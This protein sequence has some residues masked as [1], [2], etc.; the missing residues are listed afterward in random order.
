MRRG[1]SAGR[2]LH[3]L[4]LV[5][6]WLSTQ[7]LAEPD[8]RIERTQ[9][10]FRIDAS[11][12][13]DVHHHI[14]W[15]VMTDYNN[16][17]AFVPGIRTSQVVSVPGEPL[18]VRQTGQ[19]GFLF[20]NVPVEVVTRIEEFPLEAI[21]F[22]AVSGNLK[23]KS[24]EWRI[25]ARGEATLISYQANIVPGFWVPPLIGAAVIG[26]DVRN[27]LVGVGQEMQRRAASAASEISGRS[28][29]Q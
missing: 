13:V 8:I 16:Q 29:K 9:D 17:A 3:L 22:Y 7:T 5:L 15:Q 1:A 21:R 28:V 10:T 4:L 20:F 2:M 6:L 12:T 11:L 27:K 24:G 26:Q 19:S 25:E 23:N 14:A 18:L